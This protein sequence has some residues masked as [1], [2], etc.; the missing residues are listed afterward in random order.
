MEILKSY[1]TYLAAHPELV[2]SIILW[3]ISMFFIY[4]IL[5]K[6]RT[7]MIEGSAGQNTFWEMPEQWGY[8]W[9]FV[10][11]PITCYSAFFNQPLPDWVWWFNCGVAGYTIGGRWIF[12]WV[13]ALR[14]GKNSVQTDDKQT[15]S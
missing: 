15:P 3:N 10:S 12:E 4:F 6:Y 1:L 5:L 11:A 7:K 13:L 14:S 9:L 2:N 8:I